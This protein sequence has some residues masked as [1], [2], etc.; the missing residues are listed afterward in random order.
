MTVGEIID[1]L[2]QILQDEES[3]TR[4]TEAYIAFQP[5]YPIAAKMIGISTDE[6]RINIANLDEHDCVPDELVID[7]SRDS[8][9]FLVAGSSPNDQPY[10]P[11]SA[12]DELPW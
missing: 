3:V 8:R 7:E 5:T 11:K 10:A 1:L 12:W 2:E 6:A 9:L 4:D